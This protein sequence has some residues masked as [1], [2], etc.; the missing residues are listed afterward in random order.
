MNLGP[1]ANFIV[2]AY[3]A[4][5]AIVGILVAWVL[6]ERWRLARTLAELE[7]RGIMRR[8]EDKR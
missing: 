3:A 8:S 2:G 6:I 7:A 1:H 4:A 5:I